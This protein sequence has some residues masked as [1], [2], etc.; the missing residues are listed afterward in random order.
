MSIIKITTPFNIDLEFKIAAFQKRIAAW[1]VDLLVICTYYYLMLRFIY[2]LYKGGEALQSSAEIFLV[3]IPVMI[4]Q[5]VF[6]L[7]LNGQTLGKKVAGIKIIDTEGQEPTWGQY[8]IRWIL[9][10][11]NLYVYII[12]YLL[13]QVLY[14]G[15]AAGIV[16]VL[17]LLIL[18]LPDFLSVVI[19]ANSQRIGDF[20]A[21]T[22]VID[23]NYKSNINETIYLQ[24]EKTDYVPLFPQVMKLTDRDINGIR[25]LLNM[26]KPSNDTSHYIT[27]VALKI[28]TVLGIESDLYPLDFL[29]Q[30]LEDYNYYT[31]K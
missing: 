16:L 20:A 9:C 25:N 14:N 5:V 18:Y 26:K 12:P 6:E 13:V 22:V 10:I 8:I 28:K 7:F 31:T 1:M 15:M 11:G 21:G 4:Y 2:P 30:L 24:I 29:Q 3:V 17:V 23:K 19:S 27:D